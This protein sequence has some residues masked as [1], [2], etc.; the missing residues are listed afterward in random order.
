[1]SVPLAGKMSAL[2]L[3]HYFTSHQ[4]TFGFQAPSLSDDINLNAANKRT[5]CSL[6]DFQNG[7]VQ[8]LIPL[9][10]TEPITYHSITALV[11]TI[12]SLQCS[13]PGFISISLVH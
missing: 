4:V 9:L 10:D 2:K 11:D 1:M 12:T 8:L 13:D 3:I 5:D 7:L 6:S